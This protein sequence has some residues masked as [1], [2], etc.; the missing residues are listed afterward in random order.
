MKRIIS[1]K[2]AWLLS[3][4][5][6]FSI[7]S[8]AQ[9]INEPVNNPEWEQPF[10]P[11]RIA[12]NLYY[13]GTYDLSS[14]LIVTD[15]GHILINTGLANSLPQIKKNIEALGFQYKDI[16]IL[17]TNQVHFDHV[18]AMAAIKEETGA[19]FM[20]D[21]ADEDVCRSG[22]TTDYALSYLGMSFQP[23]VP[24]RLL[25]DGDIITLGG[26]KIT[27][28]HHPGHTKGSCSFLLDVKD[29]NK[30][31]KVLIANIPT[32]IIDGKFSEV[33]TYPDIQ[34]DYAYTFDV[35]KKIHFDLWVAA[36][37]SQFGLHKKH[38]EGDAYNPEAF[39]NRTGYD[40]ELNKNEKIFKE[41]LRN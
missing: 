24:D 8:S 36:H 14:Y 10:Q 41:K 16:K 4:F 5:L 18:G 34:N 2:T 23:I 21:A 9:K 27:F 22:G 39:R 32:I 37:A 1:K 29:G 25:H 20:V 17:L 38:K 13:V 35:M 15:S 6:V 3:L 11:F 19:Q 12:G 30:T 33:K 26:I 28:L 7:S 31:Y 40:E